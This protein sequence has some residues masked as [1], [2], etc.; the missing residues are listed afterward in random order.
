MQVG[1]DGS[2]NTWEPVKRAGPAGS[3]SIRVARNTWDPTPGVP[4]T[5]D[6]PDDIEED[7]GTYGG[8]WDGEG[9]GSKASLEA[10]RGSWEEESIY[11]TISR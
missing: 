1:L 11:H 4:P 7:N 9:A 5:S 10:E 3:G 6:L 2:T 8:G